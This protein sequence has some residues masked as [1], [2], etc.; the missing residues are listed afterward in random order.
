[1][2]DLDYLTEEQIQTIKDIYPKEDIESESTNENGKESSSSA[3]S[4]EEND[5]KLEVDKKPKEEENWKDG[6]EEY[7]KKTKQSSG[8]SYTED[9]I[10]VTEEDM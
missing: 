1:M 9:E 4:K 6:Y 8:I 10:E 2:S 7:E 5:K 3:N